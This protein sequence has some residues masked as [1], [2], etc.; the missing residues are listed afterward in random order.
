VGLRARLVGDEGYGFTYS[1][2][3]QRCTHL[4]GSYSLTFLFNHSITNQ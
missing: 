1:H 4:T 2:Y 3:L